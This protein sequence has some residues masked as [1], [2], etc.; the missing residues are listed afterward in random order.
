MTSRRFYHRLLLVVWLAGFVLM[1]LST[2]A[3]SDARFAGYIRD[4]QGGAVATCKF[5]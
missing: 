4:T 3:Q 1:P 2:F 5:P